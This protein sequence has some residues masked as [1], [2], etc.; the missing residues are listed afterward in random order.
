MRASQR[1]TGRHRRRDPCVR[2]VPQREGKCLLMAPAI[3]TEF[4]KAIRKRPLSLPYCRDSGVGKV[5]SQAKSFAG[6]PTRWV[7]RLLTAY[8][9]EGEGIIVVMRWKMGSDVDCA[10]GANNRRCC[11]SSAQLVWRMRCRLNF[12]M[13]KTGSGCRCWCGWFDER[14]FTRRQVD[15]ALCRDVRRGRGYW[16]PRA[17]CRYSAEQETR[18]S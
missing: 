14:S 12:L 9:A 16:M 3:E 7:K 8:A 17:W 11:C 1:K 5:R 6:C 18:L 13:R 15:N 2:K 4:A 10:S